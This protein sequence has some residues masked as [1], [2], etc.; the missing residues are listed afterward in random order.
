MLAQEKLS[1]HSICSRF[2]AQLAK[3]PGFH[4]NNFK[5]APNFSTF[6]KLFSKCSIT[7]EEHNVFKI[8]LKFSQFDI[9]CFHLLIYSSVNIFFSKMYDIWGVHKHDKLTEYCSKSSKVS[10]KHSVLIMFKV[11]YFIPIA[12]EQ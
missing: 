5:N 12:C 1:A 10:I 7:M 2:G 9:F 3:G 4:T 6:R 8:T 11:I